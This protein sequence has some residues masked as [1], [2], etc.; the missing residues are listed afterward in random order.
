MTALQRC[1]RTS[2]A[3]SWCN[4][5]PSSACVWRTLCSALGYD[6]NT[7]EFAIKGGV[8]YAIDFMNPA[9]D[10]E[11]QS[12]YGEALTAD[13]DGQVTPTAQSAF[14]EALAL[15]AK[16]PRAR[17]YTALAQVQ[18]GHLDA[19]LS[20]W[21]ALEN[22]SPADAPWRGVLAGQIEATA[23]QLGHEIAALT[24]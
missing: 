8:P 11:L 22:D 18:A 5:S 23:K 10:A 9:P 14:A 6:I 21:V 13:A 24:A 12:L 7:V 1:A 2:G 17:Y 20:Q 15:E 16:E 4:N 3:R 19:A